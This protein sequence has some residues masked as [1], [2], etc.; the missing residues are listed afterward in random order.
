MAFL[1]EYYYYFVFNTYPIWHKFAKN[2]G[3][4]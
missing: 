1:L 3:M 4:F 2:L